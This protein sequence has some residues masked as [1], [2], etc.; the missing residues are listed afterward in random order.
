MSVTE[1]GFRGTGWRKGFRQR[2]TGNCL[3]AVW[4]DTLNTY[5]YI[6]I[7][8]YIYIRV[9]LLRSLTPV[10]SGAGCCNFRC[11][12][13]F[14]IIHIIMLYIIS[15]YIMVYTLSMHIVTSMAWPVFPKC[16]AVHAQSFTN[17]T[18]IKRERDSVSKYFIF[19]ESTRRKNFLL[20]MNLKFYILI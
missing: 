18:E 19:C 10:P 1:E 12:M 17:C 16:S 7:Y 6:H 2:S 8:I 14:V 20:Q 15:M 9:Y 13:C 5:I 4:A 3:M 11:K